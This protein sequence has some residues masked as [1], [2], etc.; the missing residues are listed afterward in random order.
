MWHWTNN[1]I[2]V[3]VQSWLCV[4]AELIARYFNWLGRLN[5][6][7]CSWVQ[8]SLRPTVCSYIEE[9]ASGEYHMYQ[10][11]LLHSCDYQQKTSIKLNVATDESKQ[12]KWNVTLNKRGNWS[13]CRKSALSMSSTHGLIDQ[14]VRASQRNSVVV[15]SNY[16]QASFL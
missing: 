8:V 15:V 4:W 6:T 1:K 14:S 7:E 12:P 11:I 5:G 3:P 13:S 2:G 10:F 9:S 16:T